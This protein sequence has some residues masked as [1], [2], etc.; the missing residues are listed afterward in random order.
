MNE[1]LK[2]MQNELKLSN[3]VCELLEAIGIAITST[4]GVDCHN[5]HLKGSPID[6]IMIY[7]D[8]QAIRDTEYLI[9]A[10]YSPFLVCNKDT[11]YE[12]AQIIV[13]F[14]NDYPN[15]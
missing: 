8:I 7:N 6:I 14:S 1:Y 3:D 13:Q 9:E 10:G 11:V 5:Y 12:W 15:Y 4:Y 2:P